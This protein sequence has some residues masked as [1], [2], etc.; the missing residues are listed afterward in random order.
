MAWIEGVALSA[1]KLPGS[2]PLRGPV[3]D[4]RHRGRQRLD[5]DRVVALVE[6]VVVDLED[7]DR[8]ADVV[9][10]AHQRTFG[11]PGQV[12]AVEKSE[13]PEVEQ[14]D[15][16]VL[17]VRGV[18]VLGLVAAQTVGVGPRPLGGDELLV[19]PEEL[20][21][22]RGRALGLLEAELIAGL[23]RTRLP[24]LAAR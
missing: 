11:V 10:G 6:A 24:T 23:E 20:E 14:H 22:Q 7:V 16:A 8:R 19:E 12:A 21:A 1:R 5:E 15:H 9:P 17:V 13:G 2:P 18:G 3:V 4:H